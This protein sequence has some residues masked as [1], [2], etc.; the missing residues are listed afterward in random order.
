MNFDAAVVKPPRHGLF[1]FFDES[2]D[3]FDLPGSR[4]RAKLY[5]LWETPG[6]DAGPPGRAANRDRPMGGQD[7]REAHESFFRKLPYLPQASV[8]RAMIDL[9][10]VFGFQRLQLDQM[11]QRWKPKVGKSERICRTPENPINFPDFGFCA[12]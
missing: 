8:A 6:L 2:A 1:R 10:H 7:G 9:L 3:V 4:T 11:S 5:R 12:C